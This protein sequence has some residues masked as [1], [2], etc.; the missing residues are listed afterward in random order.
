MRF[1]SPAQCC[2]K[3]NIREF[4]QIEHQLMPPPSA[5]CLLPPWFAPAQ[6]DWLGN[7]WAVD[8]GPDNTQPRMGDKNSP[9]R[10]ITA[11]TS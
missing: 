6:L 3:R 5:V 8:F 7:L 11:A 4:A 9:G 1:L 10:R 2:R